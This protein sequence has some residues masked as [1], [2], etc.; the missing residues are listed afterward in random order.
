M[1]WCPFG[2]KPLSKAMLTQKN[3]HICVIRPQ[4]VKGDENPLCLNEYSSVFIL[5]IFK[6]ISYNETVMDALA[7]IDII[8]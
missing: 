8:F 1:A 6:L 7:T 5:E 4:R 3:S 2:V